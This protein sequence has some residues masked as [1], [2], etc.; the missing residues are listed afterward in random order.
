MEQGNGM[1]GDPRT[2]Q[3]LALDLKRG[4]EGAFEILVRR[5]QGRVYAA[6][7]RVTGHREEALD[8]AQEALYKAFSRIGTWQ[9]TGQFVPWLLRLTTNQAIDHVRRRNRR[10]FERI[11]DAFG[12]DGE[13]TAVGLA[14]LGT[15]RLVHAGEIDERIRKAL[16]RLSE[17]QRT[18]FMLRHY[19][20]LPLAEIAVALGCTVGSVKVHLFRALRKLQAELGDLR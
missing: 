18:V 8:V 14:D 6:A 3:E 2:D 12:P 15:E 7:Y 17:S 9:P 5:H 10:H 19:E 1:T 4:D 11:D 16:V 13:K 20:G